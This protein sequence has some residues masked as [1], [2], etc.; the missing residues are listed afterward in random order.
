MKTLPPTLPVVDVP[1]EGLVSLLGQRVTFYCINYIYCGDLVGVNDT[2]VKLSN[3][4]IVY[5]TGS[6]SKK[7]WELSEKLPSDLYIKT[8]AIESYMILK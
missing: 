8:A 1:N 4:E 5:D 3:A 7:G 2:F 6:V